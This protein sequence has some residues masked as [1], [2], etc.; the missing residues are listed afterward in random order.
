MISDKPSNPVVSSYLFNWGV[1]EMVKKY[2][3]AEINRWWIK[4][5]R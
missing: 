1:Y 5:L 4:T 3:K 2:K